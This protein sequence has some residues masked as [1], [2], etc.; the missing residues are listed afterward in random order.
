M[1]W[2]LPTFRV[3]SYAFTFA[4]GGLVA[5]LLL[6]SR[7]HRSALN[8]PLDG[9]KKPVCKPEVLQDSVDVR[10]PSDK[11]KIDVGVKFLKK[12]LADK[13]SDDNDEQKL[14]ADDLHHE[15]VSLASPI[16][17]QQVAS[18]PSRS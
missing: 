15:H 10:N 8:A 13:Y 5:T 7:L 18:V 9:T 17:S 4:S 14:L 1:S 3:W 2:Q 16:C 12:M 6:H 11:D